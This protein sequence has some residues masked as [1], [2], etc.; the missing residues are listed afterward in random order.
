MRLNDAKKDHYRKLAK[1]QGYR[2]RAS[3]KLIQLNQKYNL[4][5]SNDY[6]IDLGAAPGGWLQVASK[7]VEPNGKVIGVDLLPIK[8]IEDNVVIFRDN[9]HRKGIEI[10]IIEINECGI[11]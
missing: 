9:I 5:R 8:E 4:I 1:E 2:S 11:E 3:F 10:E 6:V 7:I